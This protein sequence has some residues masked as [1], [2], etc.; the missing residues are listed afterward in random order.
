MKTSEKLV[1]IKAML[2]PPH[3]VALLPEK[4]LEPAQIA[5]QLGYED[6][7]DTMFERMNGYWS[8]RIWLIDFVGVDESKAYPFRIQNHKLNWMDAMIKEFKAKGD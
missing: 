7:A 8:M 4:N 6:I 3:Q 2:L 5:R 1:E